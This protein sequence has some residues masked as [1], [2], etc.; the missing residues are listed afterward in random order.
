MTTEVK[1]KVISGETEIELG[2]LQMNDY[3]IYD[4]ECYVKLTGSSMPQ[5]LCSNVKTGK[6]VFLHREMY[7]QKVNKVKM[8]AY[9]QDLEL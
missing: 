9:A 3:F 7:V 6:K 2:E 8:K 4:K 5:L 1:V